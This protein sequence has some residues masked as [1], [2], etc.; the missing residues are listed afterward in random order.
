MRSLLDQIR[1]ALRQ[2]R[3]SPGFAVTVLLTLALGITATTVIFSLVDA[4]LLE[5]LPYPQ[6]DRLVS[7]DTLENIQHENSNQLHGLVRN[8]TSYPNFFDWRSLNK[9]FQSISSYSIEGVVLGADSNGPA[10]R[11]SAVQVSSD[12]FST[13]GVSPALGRGFLRQEELPGS[14]VAVLSHDLWKTQFNSDPNILGKTVDLS[15]QKYAI[16]GVMP[17]AFDF[18]ITTT[19]NSVWIT[20]ARDAEGP[21]PSTQQRGYNQLSVIGRL[22]P[23]VTID[24]ARAEMNAI[25][26]SLAARYPDDDAQLTGV[27]VIPE[28]ED[29]VGES[30]TPL[31]VL[32]AAVSCLLLIVCANVAGLM[33]TRTSRRRGELAI[34][35]AL[36]AT[37][38]QILRQLLVESILLSLGG[39]ILG[40]LATAI[41]LR[42]LPAILPANL[43]RIHQIALSGEVL[44]FAVALSILT[45]L[46]FGVLPAWRASRQDPASALAE[47]GRSNTASRRQFRL[48][49]ALV[50]AQTAIG[51][52]L[53]VG[54]GLLIQSFNRTTHVDP[55]FDPHQMLN[56]RVSIPTARYDNAAT[57]R[58][59]QQLLLRLKALPG[60]QNA[61]ASFPLP[62][63][64]GDINISFAI[65]GRPTPPGAEPS[66]R[67]SL[68]EP[69]YF[70]TLRIPLRQGRFFLATEHN[71]KGQ[72]VAMVNEEFAKRFFP[73]QNAVGQHIQSGL[74]AGD[75]PPMREIV[76]VVGNVKRANLTEADK[77][78]YY[79]PY[80][81]APVAPAAVALRVT[82]DPNSYATE[83]RAEVAKMDKSLPTYRMQ[84]YQDDLARIT[85]QQ[86]FQTLLLTA[87]A[88]IALL[89]AALGL[90][91][92]LSYMVAQRTTEFGVRIALGAP[93]T[94]VLQLMLSRG[95]MLT[96]IG[97]AVG[98]AASAL[99]TRFVAGLLYG[100]KP[101]D[102]VT[103][104]SMTAVLLLV[105]AVACFLPA[106]QA[107]T[108]DPNETLR[109][110]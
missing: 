24:Q 67:V 77:P 96:S 92:V 40:I 56:F 59:Y 109:N 51:L 28:L 90:Y 75:P 55:G 16:V 72:P 47:N 54:A 13:L 99:L 84:S 8:D 18:P 97:L 57:T 25:Q 65:Q 23:G 103:F 1:F 82:G 45:G 22:R 106:W 80:E 76:G 98:L 52:V 36:G 95:L 68:I 85:A 37:R 19:G 49:S 60:V 105:S 79:I 88:F 69:N 9:S 87:F 53:L 100:V 21:N 43:P 81:Q 35:S 44:T 12:F 94:H 29:V 104:A 86:R 41:V 5:P 73:G 58:F 20:F 4:V 34:R 7:L 30:K 64:G 33:L 11:V 48:Q 2:L 89:L 42:L 83:V 32:F 71:E 66:A 15:E 3:K 61:T 50:V 17:Q 102:A 101:L 108:L 14:R 38:V 107:A 27:N 39:G 110:Q 31:R 6:P 91:A 62:L 93:R 10:R 26:Q 78:E 70:Q 63:T 46:L 74:G